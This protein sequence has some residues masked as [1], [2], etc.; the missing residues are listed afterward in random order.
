MT[1]TFKEITTA[2]DNPGIHL[3]PPP[4]HTH[5]PINLIFG[6]QLHVYALLHQAKNHLVVFHTEAARHTESVEEPGD[7]AS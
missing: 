3:P 2:S 7:E 4:P 6:V 1:Q 5:T